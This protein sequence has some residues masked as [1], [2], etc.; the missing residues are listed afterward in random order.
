MA[1]LHLRRRETAIAA[2]FP[3]KQTS[4]RNK[5]FPKLPVQFLTSQ[6]IQWDED[7][8]LALSDMEVANGDTAPLDTVH[9]AL[10]DDINIDVG[11][12]GIKIPDRVL[13]KANADEAVQWDAQRP[14]WLKQRCDTRREYLAI[15]Q[16][17]R[18]ST[19]LG[20]SFETLAAAER[21]DGNGVNVKPISKLR[22]IR[23]MIEST[24][25]GGAP[26][27][28]TCHPMVLNAIMQS[29]EAKDLT[30]YT[31]IVGVDAQ[32]RMLEGLIGLP[33]NSLQPSSY[34]YNAAKAGLTGTRKAMVGSSFIMGY[35]EAP[36]LGFNGLG[37]E[38]TWDYLGAELQVVGV[39]QTTVGAMIGEELRGIFA[40]QYKVVK[41]ARL[42]CLDQCV[43]ITSTNY[44][45]QGVA[46][47]D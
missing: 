4:V 11:I 21:F 37:F 5:F 14:I 19:L 45:Y 32:A 1:S 40:T 13:S 30:K 34:I 16:T 2:R 46:L 23:L 36:S 6:M 31:T 25:G 44:Q 18:S 42:Y 29:E 47:L 43:D 3:E 17:L 39:P 41:A 8:I 24:S 22:N 15:K 7:E 35:T 33:A 20:N 12:Y 26:N 27:A 9:M 38:A 28:A 10:G